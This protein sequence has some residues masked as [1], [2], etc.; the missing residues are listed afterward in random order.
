MR[1]GVDIFGGDFAPE[2]TVHGAMLAY[3]ELKEKARL[4]LFG[5]VK[6]L[7]STLLFLR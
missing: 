6:N 3:E 5:D 1:I 4:A 2:A 7:T